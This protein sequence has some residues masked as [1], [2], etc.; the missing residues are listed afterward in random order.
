MVDSHK[1]NIEV[2]PVVLNEL[3]ELVIILTDRFNIFNPMHNLDLMY[4]QPSTLAVSTMKGR[5]GFV[6]DINEDNL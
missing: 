6:T 1:V 5:F 2:D 4:N 3:D